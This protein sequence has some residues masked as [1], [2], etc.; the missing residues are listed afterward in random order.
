VEGG[1]IGISCSWGN[2]DRNLV[3]QVGGVPK[4]ETITHA[5][6]S[7][8]THLRKAVLVMPGKNWKVQTRL[9]VREGAP[10]Q[11]TRNFLNIIKTRMEKLAAGP[12]WVPDTKTD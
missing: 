9:L 6:E 12:G 4:I 7:R 8:G 11:Q 1:V 2:K 3:L 5:H 10:H